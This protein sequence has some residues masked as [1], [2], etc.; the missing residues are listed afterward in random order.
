MNHLAIKIGE[1]YKLL[2]KY[3]QVY[4]MDWQEAQLIK[5]TKKGM[6]IL[7]RDDGKFAYADLKPERL[8]MHWNDPEIV[9]A[10]RTWHIADNL[11]DL[12]NQTVKTDRDEINE[13]SF[14]GR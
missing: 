4:N 5:T 9:I 7:L 11:V 2:D 12:M 6:F 8:N 13:N 3:Y 10:F 14:P 1:K